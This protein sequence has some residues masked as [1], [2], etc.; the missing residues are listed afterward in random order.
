MA[1]DAD[2]F[3]QLLDTVERFVREK[4]VPA[5]ARIAEEDRIPDEIR[6]GMRELGLFGLTVPPEYGGVGL[7][8]SEEVRLF[9]VLGQTSPAI[10]SIMGTNNGIGSQ[11]IV[12]D[13]TQDQKNKYLP[14]LASGEMI[15]S[16]ALTEPEAGSDAASLKTSAQIGRAH[17]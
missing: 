5:E 4:L 16:F 17:V 2:T 1:M 13:G 3:K 10:R 12:L 9:F 7:T 6:Q 11:G 15:G 14:K 8:M